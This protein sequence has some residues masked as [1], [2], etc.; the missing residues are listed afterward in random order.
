MT[1]NITANSFTSAPPRE[2]FNVGEPVSLLCI[3]VDEETWRVLNS[4][5]ESTGLIQLCGR[6]GEYRGKDQ[7]ALLQ[8][9]GNVAPNIC[10][11]DFDRDGESAAVVSERIHTG[12]PGIAVFA[13]ASVTGREAIQDAMFA[14]LVTYLTKALKGEQKE[15]ARARIV[16]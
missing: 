11:L 1:Q 14:M 16:S 3:C 12:I 5:A 4:F 2:T 9:L 7:D 6:V 8:S 15:K 13:I 10:L